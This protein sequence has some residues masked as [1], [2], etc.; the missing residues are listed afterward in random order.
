MCL[1][2]AQ[3]SKIG[4]DISSGFEY[5]INGKGVSLKRKDN[6]YSISDESA[7]VTWTF[8]DFKYA[9][10]DLVEMADNCRFKND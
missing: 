5:N 6:N 9:L 8:D 3:T 1:N 10:L 7:K 4:G 2:Y